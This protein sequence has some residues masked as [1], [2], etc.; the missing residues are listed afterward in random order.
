MSSRWP[1][2]ASNGLKVSVRKR[3]GWSSLG[4]VKDRRP[5][6]AHFATV[7]SVVGAT[8]DDALQERLVGN[9]LPRIWAEAIGA[10]V[11]SELAGLLPGTA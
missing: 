6:R 11:A 5:F 10:H 1:N 7:H 9:A 8:Q 2:A 3:P 4:A